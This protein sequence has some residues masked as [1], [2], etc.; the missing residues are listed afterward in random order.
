M[1]LQI[2]LLVCVLGIISLALISYAAVSLAKKPVTL[3]N[4]QAYK[5]VLPLKP[6]DVIAFT[7]TAEGKEGTFKFESYIVLDQPPKQKDAEKTKKE[8]EKFKE[9][10]A[11]KGTV[12]FKV[13]VDVELIQKKDNK[14]IQYTKDKSE[15]YVISETDKKALIKTKADNAKLCPT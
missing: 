14:K 11:K 2:K 3:E 13:M 8:L 12:P 15:I 1:K 6:E 4:L 5:D 7:K 9:K 10:Y